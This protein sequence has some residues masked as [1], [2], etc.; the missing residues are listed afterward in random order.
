[1]LFSG[2]FVSKN[3]NMA[4]FQTHS[5]L[6]LGDVIFYVVY[7][8]NPSTIT[9]M[10]P[11]CM[12]GRQAGALFVCVC[13]MLLV[14]LTCLTQQDAQLL[15][16]DREQLLLINSTADEEQIIDYLRTDHCPP[17]VWVNIPSKLLRSPYSLRKKFA[18]KEDTVEASLLNKRSISELYVAGGYS[19]PGCAL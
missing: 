5:I 7:F 18:G 10:A 14:W 3:T 11:M 15:S 13:M 17:P 2:L 9:K 4:S 16:Y 8:V 1:M 12:A 6:S 19:A